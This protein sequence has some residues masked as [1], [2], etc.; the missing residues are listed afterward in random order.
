[1]KGNYNTKGWA[2]RVTDDEWW[3]ATNLGNTQCDLYSVVH[4]EMGHALIFHPANL[5]I[6]AA[7]LLGRLKGDRLQAYLGAAPHVD[8]SD[9]LDGTIDPA[10][11]R[12]AFGYEYHGKVPLGRWLITK[13]DL[14]SAQA[15]GYT[16]R[17][18][19]AFAP[20]VLQ[21]DS[22][23]NATFATPY[24]KR[25][26]AAGGIPFY[27]WEIV[28]GELPKGLALDRFTGQLDGSPQESGAFT[29]SVRVRD[30]DERSPGASRRLHLKVAAS[31]PRTRLPVR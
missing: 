25:L 17:P 15:I 20:L 13:T 22:L 8:S 7:K 28:D 23:P 4:H 24:S 31:P 1:V 3:K 6:L 30:Y 5:R 21:T 12:G 26:R 27:D 9:H 19:S 29:F 2:V 16:L 18:T 14:L 11:L 10:S